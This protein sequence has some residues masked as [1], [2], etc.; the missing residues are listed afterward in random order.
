[1]SSP[2]EYVPLYRRGSSEERT[3][4]EPLLNGKEGAVEPHAQSYLTD[5]YQTQHE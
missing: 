2:V 1:M 4:H 5:Q 3:L